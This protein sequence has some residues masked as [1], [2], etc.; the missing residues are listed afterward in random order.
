LYGG[1]FADLVVAGRPTADIRNSDE[2]SLKQP[3]DALDLC[4]LPRGAEPFS[5]AMPLLN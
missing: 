2:L 5:S 3:L 1:E 4:D